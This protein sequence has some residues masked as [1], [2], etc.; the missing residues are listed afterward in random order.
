MIY[1]FFIVDFIKII[2]HTKCEF[3]RINWVLP[4][5]KT[6]LTAEFFWLSGLVVT[7]YFL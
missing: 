3:V 1:Y 2:S 5:P 6:L 4:N 7:R